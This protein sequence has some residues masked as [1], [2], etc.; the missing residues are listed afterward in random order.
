MTT[1]YNPQKNRA[2]PFNKH[3]MPASILCSLDGTSS[4]KTKCFASK[5]QLPHHTPYL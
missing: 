2:G 4:L 5:S 1:T 3:A